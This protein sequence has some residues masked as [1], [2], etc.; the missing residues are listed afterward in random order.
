MQE[1][2]LRPPPPLT[3]RIALLV[4]LVVL[5]G[6]GVALAGRIAEALGEQARLAEER[7]A[8][9]EAAG[10]A[11]EVTVVRPEP[12]ETAPVV[13][14]TGTLEPAQAADLAFEVPGQ[15]ARVDVA[16]G[17]EVH[18]GEVLVSLDRASVGA[19]SA[20]SQAAIRVAEANAEMARDR[21]RLL[22]PLVEGGSMPERQLTTARQQLA[23]AEAQLSQAQA[24]RRQI[25]ASS[26]DHVL[27]A[28]F[29]GVVTQVPSGVGVAATPG[30]ALA[31]VEDL[32]RLRLRT[33]VNRRELEA[34]RVGA[35]VEIDGTQTQGVLDTVVRSLD[36]ATRRAPVEVTV[37][38][39][40]GELVANAFVRA[41]ITVGQP[42]PVLSL[43]STTL[44]PD[45]TVLVIGEESRVVARPV[46][47][48]I[49]PDGSWLISDGLAPDSRVVLRPAL[50]HEGTVVVPVEPPTSPVT[51]E[52]AP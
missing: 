48:D 6:L 5:A 1:E 42:R 40:D 24:G 25:A 39:Q 35:P 16:L 11:R 47:A 17:Q 19:A 37:P 14:L 36:V 34:L 18:E 31:R 38:N 33:T 41:R 46:S 51:A 2:P 32:T 44:R 52:L 28:P 22:E 7:E 4:T 9:A 45:G 49:G 27:R 15:V 13:V 26:A 3:K 43:P 50:V 29:D 23:V 30:A 8:A 10:S 21:V 12:T 20:Q